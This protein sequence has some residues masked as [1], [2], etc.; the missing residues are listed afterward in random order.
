MTATRN[1]LCCSEPGCSFIGKNEKSLGMH[2]FRSKHGK[3]KG[4]PSIVLIPSER[5][6]KIPSDKIIPMSLDWA[7]WTKED[8]QLAES[9]WALARID[10][11]LE[12]SSVLWNEVLN[13]YLPGLKGSNFTSQKAAS[14]AACYHNVI[15]DNKPKEVIVEKPVVQEVTINDIVKFIHDIPTSALAAELGRRQGLLMDAQLIAA[16]HSQETKPST[17]ESH[18]ENSWLKKPE[19]TA[20]QTVLLNIDVVGILPHHCQE[21]KMKYDG[22][23]NFKFIPTDKTRIGIRTCTD[24]VI[25]TRGRGHRHDD[26]ILMALRGDKARFIDLAYKNGSWLTVV[27][28]AITELLARQQQKEP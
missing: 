20:T 21:L 8:Q 17:S 18:L 10:K 15:N 19:P 4:I 12:D 2:Q 24:Y 7:K 22:K 5:T 9:Q 16:N 1:E 26:Q 25:A 27:D 6:K 28:E 14:C 3:W 13:E 11:P 23:V